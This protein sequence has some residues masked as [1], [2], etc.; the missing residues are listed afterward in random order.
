MSWKNGEIYQCP[1]VDCACEVTV[2]R[3]PDPDRG[4][5]PFMPTCCCGKP[6]HLKNS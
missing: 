1:D 4:G 2:T 5:G 3:P 6:M